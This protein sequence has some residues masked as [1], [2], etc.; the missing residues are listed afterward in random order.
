MWRVFVREFS[1]W[2]SL[3]GRATRIQWSE[4]SSPPKWP[5]LE[6]RRGAVRVDGSLP[7]LSAS[8]SS[9]AVKAAV[10]ASTSVLL[11]HSASVGIIRNTIAVSSL[12]PSA[13]HPTSNL[14]R[15]RR[16]AYRLSIVE[17]Y[18]LFSSRSFSLSSVH[19]TLRAQLHLIGSFY[20]L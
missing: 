5:S 9:A 15:D 8:D 17:G 18:L 4:G 13:W 1:L 19:L 6:R 12:P 16:S 10:E 2:E 11:P 3:Q 14:V 20:C 7:A